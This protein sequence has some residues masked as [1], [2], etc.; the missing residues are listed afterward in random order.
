MS[1]RL[2]IL[3][4]WEE[5]IPPR[6]MPRVEAMAREYEALAA[7]IDR[8]YEAGKTQGIEDLEERAE[9]LLENLVALYD[10]YVETEDV[11]EDVSVEEQL[12]WTWYN[13]QVFFDRES[14]IANMRD[15]IETAALEEGRVIHP[16]DE[17]ILAAA[18]D[19]AERKA[20]LVERYKR[21]GKRRPSM[22]DGRLLRLSQGRFMRRP[23]L[24]TTARYR[25]W[26]ETPGGPMEESIH[27]IR[28]EADA[29]VRKALTEILVRAEFQLEV[30]R[31]HLQHPHFGEYYWSAQ[32]AIR[33]TTQL[34]AKGLVAEAVGEWQAFEEL[35]EAMEDGGEIGPPPLG[36]LVGRIKVEMDV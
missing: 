12:A 31:E 7:E 19:A 8:R 18:Q 26:V 35:D 13:P 11:G 1:A 24:G 22:G 25:V 17:E 4:G 10:V 32:E 3:E 34:L 6:E 36:D 16:T 29:Y 5:I 9:R 15:A 21:P 28:S 14:W 27:M 23:R 20:A 2:G 33:R 30:F